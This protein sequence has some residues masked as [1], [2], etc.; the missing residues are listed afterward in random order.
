MFIETNTKPKPTL[1]HL[2]IKKIDKK[3]NIRQL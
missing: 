1:E 3:E 2:E